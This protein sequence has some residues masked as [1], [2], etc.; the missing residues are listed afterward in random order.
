MPITQMTYLCK[1][2][3]RV[4]E[5][6]TNNM[7]NSKV[8]K[9]TVCSIIISL[10]F[11]IYGLVHSSAFIKV[12]ENQFLLLNLWKDGAQSALRIVSQMLAQVKRKTIF[13]IKAMMTNN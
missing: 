12:K 13:I 6:G 3:H 2:I 4:R 5:N 9:N 1:F 8:L 10:Y 11:P 7:A